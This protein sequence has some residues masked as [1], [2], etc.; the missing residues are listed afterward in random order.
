MLERLFG[1]TLI[2]ELP[3]EFFAVSADL[4]AGEVVVHRSGRVADALEAALAIPGLMA[5][6]AAGQRLLVDAGSIDN[7]PVV[8]MA[9][10]GEGAIVAVDVSERDSGPVLIEPAG[11]PGVREAVARAGVLGSLS[12][13]EEARALATVTVTPASDGAGLLEFHQLD[14]LRAA[15]RRAAREALAAE[16]RELEAAL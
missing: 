11:L 7:L 4:V 6:V 9:E 15:G 14:E 2:Q 3:L 1:D 16:A 10:R 5:P 8:A 12:A 13:A